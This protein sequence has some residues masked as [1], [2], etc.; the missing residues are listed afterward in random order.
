MCFSEKASIVSFTIGTIGSALCISLGTP[1]D[2]II[3][4]FFIFTSLMQLVEYLLWR[5]QKC[6]DYNRFISMMGMLLN[7]LQPIFLGLLVIFFNTRLNNSSMN[8]I[9]GILATY[10][11]I[12]I[13]YSYE[14]LALTHKKLQCTIKN[15][16]TCHLQ[17]NWNY[18]RYS[19][20]VYALFLL[21]DVVIILFGFPNFQQALYCAFFAISSYVIS[22]IYY[23]GS[24]GALW[25]YF[26][27]FYPAIYYLLRV[28][29][30][31]NA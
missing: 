17:W 15:K 14:F 4:F 29:G 28:S 9:L 23:P 20:L 30:H 16:T 12:I 21:A 10:L 11:L 3:G 22:F 26:S 6:D 24:V 8:I 27:V 1:T 31:L 25:C 13:P 19:S 7:H 5:H 18:M 2:K